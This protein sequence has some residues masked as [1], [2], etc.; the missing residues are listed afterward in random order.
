MKK[1]KVTKSANKFWETLDAK[2]YKQVGVTIVSLLTESKPHDSQQMKG[3]KN[4][5]RRVDIGEYRI[6]YSENADEGV[7]EILV[8]G[9][10]NG[11][12]VYQV[13]KRK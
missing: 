3:A 13:W 11:D 8:I 9:K 10:R 1:L 12:E 4:G 6:I 7:I 2:Q 5:E